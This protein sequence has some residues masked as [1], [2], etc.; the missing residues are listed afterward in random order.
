[1]RVS[2]L[3]ILLFANIFAQ[4]SYGGSPKFYDRQENIEFIEPDRDNIIDR[5]FSPMVFQFGEEYAINLNILDVATPIID[6]GIYTYLLGISSPGAYGI[7]F[8]FDD[9]YLSNNSTLF[10]YDENK[11]MFLGS[12]TSENNKDSFLEKGILLVK[13]FDPNDLPTSF[14]SKIPDNQIIGTGLTE[15][16]ENPKKKLIVVSRDINMR[17]KCDAIGIKSE[18]FVTGQVVKSAS[19]LYTGFVSH[20]VD[21]QLID[22]FY[23]GESIYLEEEKVKFQEKRLYIDSINK[24]KIPMIP[25]DEL[26]NSARASFAAILSLKEKSWIFV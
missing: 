15:L 26:I 14:D 20:L 3:F 24:G 22:R 1:M 11:T 25:V 18:D 21:D 9:F 7:G 16:R 13:N 2:I 10:I 6:N 8:I 4:I 12:F 19:S 17:V 23:S 5:D